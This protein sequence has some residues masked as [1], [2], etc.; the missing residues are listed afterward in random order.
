MLFCKDSEYSK[1]LERSSNHNN[2]SLLKYV[3]HN[4]KYPIEPIANLED[5][6]IKL[7]S[8][9]NSQDSGR[10]LAMYKGSLSYLYTNSHN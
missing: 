7:A 9:R 8:L 10:W 4:Y 2:Y 1:G 5:N 6:A 3:M